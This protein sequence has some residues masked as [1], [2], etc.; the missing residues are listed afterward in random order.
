MYEETAAERGLE[1]AAEKWLLLKAEV[2]IEE[3][4]SRLRSQED[5]LSSL[6]AS[7]QNTAQAERLVELFKG[8]LIEWERHRVLIEQRIAHLEHGSFGSA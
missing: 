1:I 8:T 3:G 2:D 4:W 5:L 6:R 7:G